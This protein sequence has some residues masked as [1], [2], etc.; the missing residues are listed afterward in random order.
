MDR[1]R[2][3]RECVK[4][5]QGAVASKGKQKAEV[6]DVWTREATRI[7][8]QLKDLIAFLAGIRRAY[9]D[10]SQ[11]HSAV[12]SSSTSRSFDPKRPNATW[13][14][15]KHLSDRERDEIDYQTQLS[16]K[17]CREQIRELENAEALRKTNES[18][19]GMPG[20]RA[21]GATQAKEQLAA[22]R[23]A[24]TLFLNKRL[25]HVSTLQKNQ[26]EA[27]IKRS[28][29]RS[30]ASGLGLSP[31]G[32]AVLG[33]KMASQSQSDWRAGKQRDAAP[34]PVLSSDANGV[35]AMYAPVKSGTVQGLL[36]EEDEEE[37]I[38]QLLTQ[39][40][41]QLFESEASNMLRATQDQL[42]SLR[43]AESSLL[44]ISA[45]QSELVVHLT[46]QSELTDRL[47][48]DAII[49]SDRV[50]QGNKQLQKAKERNRESRIWLLIFL[51]G[52]SLTLLFLDSF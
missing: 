10:L 45:L 49:V 16:L 46:Q 48:E 26:Q 1:S 44:E 22:H 29:E 30:A 7:A 13:D 41:I 35:P 47:Y 4:A 40:Q 33:E 39:E 51:L 11:S 28:L 34:A 20:W 27:R 38:D 36:E 24:I 14:S 12:A 9:L 42:A 2:E 32:L 6:E 5:R 43:H 37:D 23:A 25:T 15:V 50:E 8:A 21:K 18:K 52:A 3:F 19:Q 17:T 31:A